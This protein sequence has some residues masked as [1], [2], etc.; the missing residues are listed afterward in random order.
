MLCHATAAAAVWQA[1]GHT[2]TPRECAHDWA[3]SSSAIS[4]DEES[5]GDSL[6]PSY[7]AQYLKRKETLPT[8]TVLQV[9]ALMQNDGPG[10]YAIS[11]LTAKFGEPIFTGIGVGVRK[12]TAI[13]F[14][15][16][17]GIRA[18]IDA[19]KLILVGDYNHW[20]VVYGYRTSTAG[21]QGVS[22]YNPMSGGVGQASYT[23]FI[24]DKSEFWVVG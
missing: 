4:T 21:G 3:F 2:K 17:G 22:Y 6:Y 15:G 18:E 5:M 14:T 24:S 7:Q 16:P 20:F 9:Q 1:F 19:N 10:R 8:G 23:S 11:E 12:L 13:N